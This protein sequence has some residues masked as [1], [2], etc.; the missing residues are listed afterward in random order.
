M[1][2][3]P[4]LDRIPDRLAGHLQPHVDLEWC[5]RVNDRSRYLLRD[6]NT[7]EVWKR[8]PPFTWMTLG[9]IASRCEISRRE[10][11]RQLESMEHWDAAEQAKGRFRTYWLKYD[12]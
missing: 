9:A 6:P 4:Q 2:R 1:P 3:Q 7:E 8:M 10:A 11:K 12:H 5:N